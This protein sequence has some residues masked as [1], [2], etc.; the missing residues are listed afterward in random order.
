MQE[1]PADRSAAR[2]SAPVAAQH[3]TGTA[4]AHHVRLLPWTADGK[5]CVLSTSGPGGFLS[6][7]ADG[8]E[9]A[10]LDI[11][12]DVLRQGCAVLADPLSPYGEVRYAGVRLAEC[13]RDALGIAE[14]RGLRVPEP[15]GSE[16]ESPG[17]RP[18]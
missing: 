11:G 10:Q 5:L 7:L 15:E 17:P 1:T 14:S 4:P 13:L 2:S 8:V 12:Y 6:R 3:L 9:D 18:A 16:A